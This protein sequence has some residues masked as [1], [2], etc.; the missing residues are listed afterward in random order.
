MLVV[1]T[2]L[3]KSCRAVASWARDIRV[4][5][6]WEWEVAIEDFKEAI[7]FRRPEVSASGS[8]TSDSVAFVSFSRVWIARVIREGFSYRIVSNDSLLE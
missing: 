7:C 4:R 8:T 3:Y 5:E 6:I 2:W 1:R